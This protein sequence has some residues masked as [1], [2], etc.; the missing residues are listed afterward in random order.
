MIKDRDII[1]FSADDW[2]CGLITSQTHIAKVLSKNN[3]ILYINS[4]GLRRPSISTHDAKKIVTKLKKCLAGIN[5]VE[6]NVYVVTPLVIPFHQYSF[7][8]Q[9][10]RKLLLGTIKHFM[11]KLGFRRPILWTYL[12]NTGDFVKLLKEEQSLYYCV[13]EFSEFEGVPAKEIREMEEKLMN[14]TD[15]VFCTSRE[16]FN[17]KS[18]YNRNSFYM[19]HGVDIDHFTQ[20]LDEK[21]K[22]PDDIMLI[23]R[24]R[25]GFYGGI[26]E[27][28][29]LE[30]LK[31]TAEKHPDWHLVLIG[32]EKVNTSKLANLRNVHLLGHRPYELLPAYSKGF[33]VSL[34]PFVINEL[35]RNVNP[36]KLREYLAA[37][38]PVVSTYLPEL[39]EYKDI[40]VLASNYDEFIGGIETALRDN[41]SSSREKRIQRVK[42][43]SWESRVEQ[44]SNII[45]SSLK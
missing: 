9:I 17:K 10:N 3:R 19:P 39:E 22:I 27:W 28:V 8:R 12:P 15:Y 24:P 6:K 25:I 16:L 23:P 43:E 45:L 32:R 37:G 1:Y 5:Q 44:V 26:E 4:I 41:S 7:V 2:G 29:D 34:I 33:D 30:L 31:Q 18:K 21:T 11:K 40:I 42:S 20:A 13:D 36:I 35:T 38:N 14:K